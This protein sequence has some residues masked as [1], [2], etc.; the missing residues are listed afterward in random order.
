MV[1]KKMD[2][3]INYEPILKQLLL[4]I[5]QADKKHP[6]ATFDALIGE[7]GE[8]AEERKIWHC[9]HN[10]KQRVNDELLDVACV[11]IRIITQD[12]CGDYLR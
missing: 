8:V 9:N 10:G 3:N 7:V 12:H 5:R 6:R 4:R 11:A 1:V 2:D